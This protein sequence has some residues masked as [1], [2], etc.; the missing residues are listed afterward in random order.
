[1]GVPASKQ[2][3][4]QWYH[5]C[6]ELTKPKTVHNDTAASVQLCG[7]YALPFPAVNGQA[8]PSIPYEAATSMAWSTCR[9]W[10]CIWL[11]GV[12]L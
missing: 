11:D 4:L 10:T 6:C 9:P 8:V 1:M 2:Q 7:A 3:T 5:A 12:R